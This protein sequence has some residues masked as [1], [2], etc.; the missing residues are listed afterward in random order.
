MASRRLEA[1]Y[2]PNIQRTAYDRLML[3]FHDYLKRNR[4][5]Q[6]TC[7]KYRWELPPGAAWIAFIDIVPHAV[8]AG[9]YALE[10]TAIVSRRVLLSASRAPIEILNRLAAP[11]SAVRAVG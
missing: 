11:H 5:Y 7:R 2:A 4:E 10:Q 3:R 6:Q 9:Q 8:V 1:R